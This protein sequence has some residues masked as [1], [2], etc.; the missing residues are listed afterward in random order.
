MARLLCYIFLFSLIFSQSHTQ[1]S[2]VPIPEETN[3]HNSSSGF[4]YIHES[5]WRYNKDELKAY[6]ERILNRIR[7]N[8]IDQSCLDQKNGAVLI[9]NEKI[10]VRQV[11][12]F[13][14][15]LPLLYLKDILAWKNIKDKAV[16]RIFI[17]PKNPNQINFT[18]HM[19]YLGMKMDSGNN[20]LQ[21]ESDSFTIMQEYIDGKS[22]VG[23]TS[24]AAYGHCDFNAR[25]I[26]QT[27]K[28]VKYLI[29]TK[30]SKNFFCPQLSPFKDAF[31]AYWL[32]KIG[33]NLP[34]DTEKFEEWQRQQQVLILQ[35]K[36]VNYQLERKTV[37]IEV[38]DYNFETLALYIAQNENLL[39][40]DDAE[41][42][43][44]FANPKDNVARYLTMKR[45][46]LLLK[47]LQEHP[48]ISLEGIVAPINNY[49][50][51]IE[52]LS[53]IIDFALD[54][55]RSNDSYEME[56]IIAAF[57]TLADSIDETTLIKVIKS[58]NLS[59]SEFRDSL[60][61]QM[62]KKLA[63]KS[64]KSIL[65][66]ASYNDPALLKLM[67]PY[68]SD[69]DLLK[70][71]LQ[72]LFSTA[73]NNPFSE[74]SEN[75]R[76]QLVQMI[77]ENVDYIDTN[78]LE[79]AFQLGSKPIL[80]SITA[81]EFDSG[82]ALLKAIK[83]IKD[84]RYDYIRHC[85]GDYSPIDYFWYDLVGKSLEKNPPADS[86]DNAIAHALANGKLKILEAILKYLPANA[87]HTM[88]EV[89]RIVNSQ[90]S[91]DS[92]L[93]DAIRTSNAPVLD[94]L[95]SKNIK[96]QIHHFREALTCSR[97]SRNQAAILDV[98]INAKSINLPAALNDAIDSRCSYAIAKIVEKIDQVKSDAYKRAFKTKDP[99]IIDIITGRSEN[100][101]LAQNIKLM[102]L[103]DVEQ[104]TDPDDLSMIEAMVSRNINLGEALVACVKL[105]TFGPDKN[106]N[107]SWDWYGLIDKIISKNPPAC[108]I[109]RAIAISLVNSK[110]F[111][112]KKIIHK[113][114]ADSPATKKNIS[115]MLR[116]QYSR[117]NYFKTAIG[118]NNRTLV[119]LFIDCGMRVNDSHRS[120]AK[121]IGADKAFVD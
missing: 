58:N 110:A 56:N 66:A 60:L 118:L 26:I 25:Q 49:P 99:A 53:N 80:E 35:E 24:F 13:G 116:D 34:Q 10:K 23:D 108:E 96:I 83:N 62:L 15:V 55:L 43:R 8:F 115:Q 54:G 76:S 38:N 48:Q 5:F 68:Y 75:D 37:E 47:L 98:L 78:V 109:D 6:G 91:G 71:V 20:I 102:D 2:Y 100:S 41:K 101:D 86:I 32:L 85:Q 74:L 90:Y 51:K 81:K 88:R 16:P 12:E 59:S 65:A 7:P 17:I 4:S 30:E 40:N 57:T 44:Y 106:F 114:P 79:A 22:F 45:F 82:F 69:Q 39:F 117:E 107:V 21:V 67:L 29:D 113:I 33:R 112:L 28:G 87:P 1:A 97:F 111:I 84:P 63:M 94:L 89:D 36:A 46:D 61:E 120:Y 27:T 50:H 52:S 77:F 31:Q 18:F 73:M 95:V 64:E 92:F 3:S 119:K 14:R 104:L 19:P 103:Y 72:G 121:L 9:G 93:E 11:N 70:K 105:I 42:E